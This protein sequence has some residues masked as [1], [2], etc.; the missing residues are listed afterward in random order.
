MTSSCT[1]SKAGCRRC[2]TAST[3]GVPWP[4]GRL[5]QDTTF[6]LRTAAG[7]AV[8]VQSWPL[9]SWPDGSLK[10]TAHAVGAESG[11]AEKLLLAA[12][13]PAAPA[14]PVRVS[15]TADAI[16]VDTG[17]D[18][19]PVPKKGAALIASIMRDGRE[20]ARDGRLVA[21]CDDRPAEGAAAVKTESFVSEIASV[22][23]EQRGPVR[24]VVKI[25][26]K[27]ADD[28]AGAV[29]GPGCRSASGSIFTPAARRC[30]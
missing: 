18:P 11:Q 23:I 27:H 17:R 16:E 13:T 19:L 29:N 20:I 26:G 5:A 2:P 28:A 15:E 30:G 14:Q 25:E 9:A 22:T 10:W 8:P 21:L 12:G 4:R 6:A 7:E 24:A 3:W 1:G